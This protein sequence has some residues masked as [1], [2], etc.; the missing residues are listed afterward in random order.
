MFKRLGA[1]FQKD[2]ALGI[3]NYYIAIMLFTAVL[4]VLLVRFVIPEETSIKPTVY[5]AVESEAERA[6]AGMYELMDQKGRME[7]REE[8]VRSM[9]GNINSLGMVFKIKDR[10]PTVEYILQGHENEKIKNLLVLPVQA[11]FNPARQDDL[12]IETIRL[13]AVTEEN[14]QTFNMMLLPLLVL[15]E[16]ALLGLMLL[17]TM[18]FMEKEEKTIQAYAVTPGQL[19]EFLVSKVC[20]ILLM[21]LISASII[22]AFTVGI[23]SNFILLLLVVGIS[24]IFSSTLALVIASFFDNL[25]KAMMWL[26]FA[27]IVLTVPMISYFMPGFA[28]VWIRI[29]PTYPLL[30]VI[31][32]VLFPTGNNDMIVSTLVL[33]S[34]LSGVLFGISVLRYR[35]N[36]MKA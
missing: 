1:L 24:S 26:M 34:I 14:D 31:Q 2:L 19:A 17:A 9:E 3:R 35:G 20:F 13:K 25:S 15:F 21:S 29:M 7:S 32:E 6:F 18:I 33:F 4:L 22:V 8:I 16:P 30:F 11:L 12:Q 5:Y 36:L 10:K 23:G 28:P 27:T